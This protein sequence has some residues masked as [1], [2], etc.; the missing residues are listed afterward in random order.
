MDVNQVPGAIKARFYKYFDQRRRLWLK[1]MKLV[2]AVE[3]A[4]AVVTMPLRKF[5]LTR[6]EYVARLEEYLG[7]LKAE[8]RSVEAE[9]TELR[10][11]A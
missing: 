11:T 10:Q 2:L 9:L 6:E 8:I 4:V 5:Y 7:E 3:P 1:K